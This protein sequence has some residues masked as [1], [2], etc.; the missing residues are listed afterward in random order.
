M[1]TDNELENIY[2]RDIPLEKAWDILIEALEAVGLWE[3]LGFEGIPLENALG[4]VT[5]EPVWAR[6]SSPHYYAAAM[7]GFALRAADTSGASDRKPITLQVD[8]NAT[9]VDT[10]DP[11]PQWADAVVPIE[12]VEPIQEAGEPSIRIRAA[13]APWTHV[14]AMGEDMVAT[15]LV[16]PASHE[17]RPV[18]LGAIA[19]SGH[20]EVRVWRRPRV[21]I[22]PTGTELVPIG[23]EVE[24]GETIEY[25]SLVLAAQVETWGGQATRYPSLPD[26]FERI[27]EAVSEAAANHDLV[28]VNAGSSAGSEDYTAKVVE[29]LGKLLVHGVAVRPGHPVVLGLVK[30]TPE[31]SSLAR[32]FVPVIGVPGYP[33]STALTGEIFVEPLLARWLGRPPLAPQTIDATLTR[34]VRSSLGDDEYLRVTV[35]RVGERMIAAPLSRG[36]GVITSL[37]RAD[38]IVLIPAGVQ[39]LQTGETVSVRLYRSLADVERTILVLGSHDLTIDLMAQFL[40]QRGSRLSSANLGSL[41]GLVALKRGEAHLS[42]SHLLDPES[43]E[44]N[45]SYIEK[46]LPE[47]PVVVVGYVTREQG[48]IVAPGNLKG[49]TGLADLVKDGVSFINRQPGAGTRILLDYHLGELGVDTDSITGYEREEY[50]HLAVAAAVMSGAVDCGLGIRAAA[51]A[52]KLDFIPLYNERFDLVIPLEH[53]ASTKLAPLLELLHETEFRDAVDA[54]AGYGTTPMGE[55]IAEIG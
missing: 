38:G 37:V 5:A 13:L 4:R 3:P 7:D 30:R 22:I 6:I 40:S 51:D 55:I 21:A 54:I 35:G 41:G 39:G 48:L 26:D 36:A 44:Y 43:G 47:V 34:K 16:V 33:V 14:R 18:D 27:R 2:L 53:Y 49:L 25:N 10:G 17:L 45:L 46:Y 24:P 23:S 11:L 31:G 9:Y 1:N 12:N 19:G 52:L 29:S 15:E 42:G 28:L 20:D 32:A 8:L 50:S